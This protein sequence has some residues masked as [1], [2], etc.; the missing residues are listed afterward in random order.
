MA[1]FIAF[2]EVRPAELN[3]FIETS[4]DRVLTDKRIKIVLPPHIM[5]ESV[6][7]IT[8]L[9]I[10]DSLELLAIRDY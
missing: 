2:F 1:K 5:A 4:G 10:F 9:I 7:G 8:G 6:N 3:N